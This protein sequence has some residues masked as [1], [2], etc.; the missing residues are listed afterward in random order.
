MRAA[1]TVRCPFSRSGQILR[2][3]A[4]DTG[5][6]RDFQAFAKQTGND[7]LE[8]SQNDEHEFIF[9]MKRK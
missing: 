6:V 5:S 8:Q 7:L 3:T 4:T 1:S 2:V 9:F